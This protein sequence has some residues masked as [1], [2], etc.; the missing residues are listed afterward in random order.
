MI[1]NYLQTIFTCCVKEAER[2]RLSSD[3]HC[4]CIIIKH[5]NKSKETIRQ[6]VSSGYSSH[7]ETYR[8]PQSSLT[9]L[10]VG[11]YS[12]GNLLVVQEI[13]KQVFPTAP[14]PTTTHFIVCICKT[15]EEKD[16]TPVGKQDPREEVI[17]TYYHLN[18]H[19]QLKE[20]PKRHTSTV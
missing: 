15:T 5:L 2:I 6:C 10:T 4:H 8:K 17:H 14:S 1:E 20:N 18:K 3:H 12:E 7:E 19:T 11:T 13:S 9:L 16:I